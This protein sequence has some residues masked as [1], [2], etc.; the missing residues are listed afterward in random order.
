M[1]KHRAQRSSLLA[2]FLAPIA[3]RRAFQLELDRRVSAV[4]NGVGMTVGG[5]T[6]N[7]VVQ[8]GDAT[9]TSLACEVGETSE[10]VR[11]LVAGRDD[12]LRLIEQSIRRVHQLS[13]SRAYESI[14]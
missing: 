4:L 1:S 2:Q 8:Q 12:A 7:G 14:S 9:L 11:S 10:G 3:Q 13:L 6:L 5:I